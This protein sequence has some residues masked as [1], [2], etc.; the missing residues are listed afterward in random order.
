MEQGKGFIKNVKN[1]SKVRS[2]K[3]LV[4]HV[5]SVQKNDLNKAK[6][7]LF[8]RQDFSPN[9]LDILDKYGSQE[10]QAIRLNRNPISSVL[11]HLFDVVTLNK[12]SQRMSNEPYDKLFH[13]R[14]DIRL[15]S[16]TMIC[17]EKLSHVSMGLN[18]TIAKES[19]SI[20]VGMIPKITLLQLVENTLKAVGKDRFFKYSASDCNCQDF[21]IFILNA[22]H[23]NTPE[24][25]AWVKQD[26]KCLFDNYL[27]KLSNTVTNILG[28]SEIA[29]GGE[30]E[31]PRIISYNTYKRFA[32][33]YNIEIKNKN[34]KLRTM[35]QL[36]NSI[37]KH[38]I[39]NNIARGLYIL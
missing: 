14:M 38:E 26:T 22:C 7:V 3:D 12:F 33:K 18:P 27:R 4:N 30:I 20:T 6:N 8:G 39:K 36:G 1:L 28:S 23:F 17:L 34:G 37:H 5:I 19:E 10:L 16:G 15:A 2:T 32:K 9:V 24:L 13:L 11:M 29:V 21:L 31:E 25:Q 35:K